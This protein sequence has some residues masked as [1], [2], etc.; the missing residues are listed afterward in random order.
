MH[1]SR[2]IVGGFKSYSEPVQV[3][4]GDQIAVM[5]GSNGVGKSNALDA[6][7]WALGEDDPTRLRS[8]DREDLLF[9]GT[10]TT[11]PAD[12]ASVVMAFEEDGEEFTVSRTLDRSG[13]EGFSVKGIAPHSLAAHRE[14]LHAAGLGNGRSNV[15]RQEELTDFFGK[16]AAQRREYFAGFVAGPQE[17]DAVNSRFEEFLAALIPGTRG[18]IIA[19][20]GLESIDVTV[21]FPGKGEKHGTLLSGGERAVTALAMKLAL[22]ESRPSPMY[23][24]DEVEPSLDWARNSNV[25]GLLKEVSRDRQLIMVT[26]LQSTIQIAKTVH[27]VRV[28]PDGSSW[29]KFHFVMD[30]RLFKVYRCCG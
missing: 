3:D 14:A 15:I 9:A 24:L 28:R 10:E 6:V 25:Q 27:G 29:L 2:L 11:P 4:F 7:L 21:R 13:E 23:L 20:N 8:R 5:I 12:Q 26:H 1:L 30:E 18:R 17:L 16:T 19:E 22:F